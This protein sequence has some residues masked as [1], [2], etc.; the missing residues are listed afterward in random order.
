MKI[1]DTQLKEIYAHAKEI[2]P[3]ECCG[4]L[5]GTFDDGGWV[6]QVKRATNQNQDRTDRFII[7]GRVELSARTEKPTA[8]F[9]VAFWTETGNAVASSS[10]NQDRFLIRSR[11]AEPAKDLPVLTLQ[12]RRG[13]PD[14]HKERAV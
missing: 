7:S 10:L 1:T 11:H 12:E 2:Y 13:K 14:N 9:D 3:Y 5:L 4:F 8:T 6:R